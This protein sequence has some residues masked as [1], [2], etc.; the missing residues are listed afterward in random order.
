MNRYNKRFD[1]SNKYMS[2]LVY[3]KQLLKKIQ[4]HMG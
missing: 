2:L 3:D 1:R 4:W